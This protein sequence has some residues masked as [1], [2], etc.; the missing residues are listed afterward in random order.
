MYPTE[1][2]R[3][4]AAQHVPAHLRHLMPIKGEAAHRKVANDKVLYVD[5]LEKVDSKVR[6]YIIAKYVLHAA[7][8]GG[9]GKICIMRGPNHKHEFNVY[10]MVKKT[11][12]WSGPSMTGFKMRSDC[13]FDERKQIWV[14]GYKPNPNATVS[15][16]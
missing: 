13:W 8:D 14:M 7:Q 5:G 16:P 2:Q 4:S 1:P 3:V 10:D 12:K 9:Y 15:A 6:C 11:K